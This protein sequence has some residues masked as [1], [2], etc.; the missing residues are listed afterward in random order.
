MFF[1]SIDGDEDIFSATRTVRGAQFSSAVRVANLDDGGSTEGTPFVSFDGLSLYFFSTRPGPDVVGGRDLWFTQRPSA[2][3]AFGTPV[4]VPE[5]NA[6]DLDHLPRLLPDELT[7]MFV[8]GRDSPNGASNI[9]GTERSSRDEDF[10]V[11]MEIAGVNTD[12]REEGFTLTID[13]LTLFFASNRLAAA[14]MDIWVA[15]RPRGVGAFGPAENL[16]VVNTPAI[17]IDPALST[18]G[19]EL[20]FASDRNGSMQLFR[21]ARVCSGG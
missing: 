7:L 11:P 9:W 16:T 1:S 18:D 14:D 10:S 15:T 8:S 3:G 12:A 13:G 21:T 19:F 5:V 2:D 6:V 20:F 17:E 4:V